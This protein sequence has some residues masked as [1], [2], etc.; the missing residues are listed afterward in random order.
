VL[1]SIHPNLCFIK[2]SF[3]LEILGETVD[4][5]LLKKGGMIK[6]QVNT[7]DTGGVYS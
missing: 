6:W 7:I 5:Q 4:Q 2:T 3:M 1:N